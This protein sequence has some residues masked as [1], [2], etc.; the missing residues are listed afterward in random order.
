MKESFSLEYL[1]DIQLFSALNE[2]ELL[3]LQERM[4]VKEFNKSETILHEEDTNEFMYIVLTGKVKALKITEDGKEIIL[5]IHQAGDFFGEL[6]LI[7]GK[8]SPA[9]VIAAESSIV[10]LISK[11]DFNE[12]LFT[13]NKVLKNLLH[14]FCA[15][16]RKSWET[17][18]VL[19]F[20]N[21][22]QRVKMFF[23]SLIG[24]YGNKAAEGIIL[25]IK[26]THQDIS[27]MSGLT[28][29]TVTRVMDK[30]QKN[31]EITLMKNNFIRL[32]HSLIN[33]NNRE[34]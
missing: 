22:S 26:L 1:K 16:Q 4:K 8:T 27:D 18:Q 23:L 5:A 2:A 7:D 30:L 24:E 17:I 3:K 12:I 9:S 10:A 29:E 6:T 28:R 31:N 15:R 34:F 33:Q 13:Q 32:N 21:A 11:A 14:I 19:N 25:N 20:N